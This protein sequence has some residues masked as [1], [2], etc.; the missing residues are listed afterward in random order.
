VASATGT[1]APA[2]GTTTTEPAVGVTSGPATSGDPQTP[3]GVLEDVL[4]E[5]EEEVEVAQESVPKA[6][7][8]EVPIEGAMIAAHMV[9]P[10]PSHGAPVPSPSS[11]R[12]AA[13]A[14]AASGAELEVV[15]GHPAPYALGDIP[16]D[17][18][19][20]TAHRAL[21]QV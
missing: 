15:L 18:V 11:P 7:S 3:E 20:S 10:S 21:S 12:I 19:M 2:A 5:S 13:A 4:E 8:G 16:L 6:V 9:T 1:A 14:G 17:K